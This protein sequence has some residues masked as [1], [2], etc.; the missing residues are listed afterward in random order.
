MNWT[1]LKLEAFKIVADLAAND[2]IPKEEKLEALKK[3]VRP[4][5]ETGLEGIIETLPAGFEQAVKVVYD[6]GGKEFALMF[7]VPLL[8]EEIYQVW[9]LLH[10]TAKP[11][12][13]PAAKAA[14]K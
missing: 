10:P 6:H 7:L 14:T 11:A 9:K 4:L 12:A 2:D 1:E 13:K 8:S 3:D 5:L